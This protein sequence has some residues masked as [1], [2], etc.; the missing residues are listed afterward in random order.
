MLISV[1]LSDL[2]PLRT[3]AFGQGHALHRAGLPPYAFGTYLEEGVPIP[4]VAV[5][6]PYLRP[7][8]LRHLL[9]DARDQIPVPIA[10]DIHHD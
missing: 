2:V 7:P 6:I 3:R 8:S 4:S 5:L 9:V 1:A 10:G